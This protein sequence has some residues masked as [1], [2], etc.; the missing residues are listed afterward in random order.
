MGFNRKSH[1]RPPDALERKLFEDQKD[2]IKLFWLL[3]SVL[4]EPRQEKIDVVKSPLIRNCG[5]CD[6]HAE[7]LSSA[8]T[9]WVSACPRWPSAVPK[10]V[11]QTEAIFANIKQI[12]DQ[13]AAVATTLRLSL[14]SKA[15]VAIGPFSRGGQ[16]RTGTA[17]R[18]T[19]EPE[20]RRLQ[21]NEFMEALRDRAVKIDISYVTRLKDEIKTYENDFNR[22]P[23]SRKITSWS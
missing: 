3:S 13:A 17:G 22:C 10:K 21:Y 2:T 23:A 15:P 8:S 20:Y 9:P 18:L 11:P 1:K 16:S 7:A 14:D 12:H 5:Y 4:E 19:N 6:L